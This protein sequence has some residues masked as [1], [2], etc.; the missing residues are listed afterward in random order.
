M[1]YVYHTIYVIN[2][3]VESSTV[4][5]KSTVL[6]KLYYVRRKPVLHTVEII[7]ND[8]VQTREKERKQ[9]PEIGGSLLVF[10]CYF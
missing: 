4:Y 10:W 3:T 9:K 7:R 5:Y 8:G 6:W 2:N 1:V